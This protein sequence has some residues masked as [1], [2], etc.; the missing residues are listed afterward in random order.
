MTTVATRELSPSQ[1]RDAMESRRREGAT[2]EVIGDEFG[3]TRERVRQILADSGLDKNMASTVK[4]QRACDARATT[5]TTVI[6]HVRENPHHTWA[7]IAVAL[8]VEE[9][10]LRA[11]STSRLA[12]LVSQRRGWK[13]ETFTDE[14]VYAAIR[15]AAAIH[16]EPLSVNMYAAV[17]DSGEAYGP[18]KARIL[19]RYRF[20][21][22]ACEA[23]GVV[24]GET[25]R[26]A[27]ESKWSDEDLASIVVEWITVEGD[28]PFSD[29]LTWLRGKPGYPSGPLLRQR[30][31]GWSNARDVALAT[32]SHDDTF[33]AHLIEETVAEVQSVP[34]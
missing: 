7:Q 13:A 30:F 18:S 23:A 11:L 12:R 4:R 29:V 5:L 25:Y 17:V 22:S 2:L 16:G 14:Q 31:G 10:P 15:T 6:E 9:R 20:W 26:F 27:Y 8:G 3:V 1:R 32:I 34:V 19:Q 24:P 33:W 21:S 28:G